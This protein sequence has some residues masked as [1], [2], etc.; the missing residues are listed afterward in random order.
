MAVRHGLLAHEYPQLAELVAKLWPSIL[1]GESVSEWALG[2]Q[3]DLSAHSVPTPIAVALREAATSVSQGSKPATSDPEELMQAQISVASLLVACPR[4]ALLVQAQYAAEGLAYCLRRTHDS[5]SRQYAATDELVARIQGELM[6]YI[7]D[8]A[9]VYQAWAVHHLADKVTTASDDDDV[10]VQLWQTYRLAEFVRVS[11]D[12]DAPALALLWTKFQFAPMT[13]T[14]R[15]VATVALLGPRITV[16]LSE[17]LAVTAATYNAAADVDA[18]V[19]LA[20]VDAALAAAK[21][22]ALAAISMSGASRCGRSCLVTGKAAS[23]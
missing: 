14:D 18:R 11:P 6:S 10:V 4:E 20:A 22:L 17:A 7:S 2:G 19:D 15:L 9:L 5:W 21:K 3:L 23:K 8:A 16:K 13:V 12:N 1:C